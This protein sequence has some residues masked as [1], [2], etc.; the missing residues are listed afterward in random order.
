MEDFDDDM[1]LL[2]DVLEKQK[3]EGLS[4]MSN[5]D[6]TKM[7]SREIR[8]IKSLLPKKEFSINGKFKLYKK[9]SFF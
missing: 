6:D 3:R 1:E 5:I 4:Q 2:I 7:K 8:N 9:K